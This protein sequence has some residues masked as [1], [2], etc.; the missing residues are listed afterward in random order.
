MLLQETTA[1]IRTGLKA[2]EQSAI[3]A[4]QGSRPVTPHRPGQRRRRLWAE[5]SEGDGDLEKLGGAPRER[6]RNQASPS[7]IITYHCFS[8]VATRR[9]TD[10]RW[11]NRGNW[12]QE[13]QKPLHYLCNLSENIKVI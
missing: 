3:R 4:P 9:H 1:Q 11:N 5:A 8:L 6:T 10:R 7:L 2:P 12:M 13:N